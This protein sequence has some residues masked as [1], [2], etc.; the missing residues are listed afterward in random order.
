VE[1][2]VTARYFR[3]QYTRYNGGLLLLGVFNYADVD[4]KSDTLIIFFDGKDVVQ[5]FAFAEDTELLRTL[6]PLTR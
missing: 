1:Q 5:D 3:Y 2:L 6:G 4:I